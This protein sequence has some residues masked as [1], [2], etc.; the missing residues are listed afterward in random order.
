[1]QSGDMVFTLQSDGKPITGFTWIMFW[2]CE[3]TLIA[4]KYSIYK[5]FL[6]FWIVYQLW[7]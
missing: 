1:M 3:L 6:L 5:E 7:G 2:G 4:F